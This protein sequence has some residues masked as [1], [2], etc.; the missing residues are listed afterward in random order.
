M[1]KVMAFGTFDLLHPGHIHYLKNSKKLGDFLVVVIARDSTV[2]K[3]KNK[4]PINNEN[5]RLQNII[6]L[7][8][9]DKVILGDKIDKLKVVRDEKPDVLS[10]GYDQ[11]IPVE[12]LISQIDPKIVIKRIDAFK[13]EIYKSSLL[14][15]SIV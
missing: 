8:I 12:D 13:P 5:T 10:F 9:A 7:E 3:I 2:L 15:K 1:K 14:K 11:K 6:K 4:L